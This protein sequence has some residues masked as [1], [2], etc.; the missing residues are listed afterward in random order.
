M[1]VG[2]QEMD[3]GETL[4]ADGNGEKVRSGESCVGVGPKGC[5]LPSAG[6]D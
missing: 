6:A 3:R 4:P 5:H 2:P 1:P